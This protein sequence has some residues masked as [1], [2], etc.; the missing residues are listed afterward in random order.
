MK[1]RRTYFTLPAPD[2]EHAYQHGLL[3]HSNPKTLKSRALLAIDTAVLHL[4]PATVATHD[5]AH[6]LCRGAHQGNG[7]IRNCIAWTGRAGLQPIGTYGSV[8]HA[9]Y[10]RTVAFVTDPERFTARL[11][12]EAL[13]HAD[14]A[15]KQ[16]L[17]PAVRLNGTSDVRWEEEH[18]AL[19]AALLDAG[20]LLYD[21][22]KHVDRRPPPGYELLYSH[23]GAHPRAEERLQQGMAAYRRA[24]VVFRLRPPRGEKPGDPLPAEWNGYPV[25][26]GDTHDY[27]PAHPL[28]AIVGLRA[29]GEAI[30]D[31]S[32][33]VINPE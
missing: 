29:K 2:A 4:T 8:A 26:D 15:R 24:A 20:I 7:C 33:F 31:Q 14:R 1:D 18:P 19:I 16:N 11:K 17:T 32:G 22:T 6:D 21:Y 23:S 3:T 5:P 9:R 27:W 28:D 12:K 25:A 10:Q 30:A 13:A